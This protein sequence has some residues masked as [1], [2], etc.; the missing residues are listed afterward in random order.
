MSEPKDKVKYLL[1][2]D[3]PPLDTTIKT[4]NVGAAL[5]FGI[6]GFFIF[7]SLTL[8]LTWRNFPFVPIP[9][10][11][12]P[13]SKHLLGFW[14]IVIPLDFI[15][16]GV[17][18][19]EV[20]RIR[21]LD[22]WHLISIR[23]LIALAGG[24]VGGIALL[25]VGLTPSGGD[26]HIKGKLLLRGKEA[27]NDLWREFG[28]LSKDGRGSGLVVAAEKRFDPTTQ[29]I[30][31][32]KRGSFIEQPEKVRR[33]HAMYLGGTGRGKT[34]LI[35]YRL[36]AQLYEQ[37]RRGE[38]V[39]LLIADTPKS[40]YARYFHSKHVYSIAPAE[41]GG[42]A[43]DL[44]KDLDHDLLANA[45][46]K[47]KIPHNESDPIWGN[48]AIA[49]GTGCTKFLQRVAPKA[50]NYGMLAHMLTLSGEEL[51]PL[52]KKY[53][54]EAKQILNAAGETLT[55]VMFNLGTYSADF[56]ALG[57]IYDGFDIKTE[58]H[59]ATAKALKNEAYL[60]FVCND[61][62]TANLNHTKEIENMTRSLMFKAVCRHLTSENE[63]WTWKDFARFV[64][65]PA[66]LQASIAG[67][68]LI[69]ETEGKVIYNLAS[70]ALWMKL[71]STVIHYAEE[72]DRLESQRRLS[73]REWL[74]KDNPSR[75]ILLLKPSET[76][77]TL[78]EGLIKGILYY[79]NSVILGKLQDD[80]KRRLHILID[81]FQSYGNI[82]DF[83]SPALSMYRSRGVSI[84]IAFQDLAQLVKIYGQETVDFMNSNI[85]TI[86]ILGVNDGFTANKLTELLGEKKI[87]KLHRHKN[88][89]GGA[90]EDLQEHDEKVIYANE[91]N[92]LGANDATMKIKYLSLVAGLNPAYILE[93]PIIPY[94]VRHEVKPASWIDAE[95]PKPPKLVDLRKQW[96]GS[97]TSSPVAESVANAFEPNLEVEKTL[98][99][100]EEEFLNAALGDD[101][102]EPDWNK[103]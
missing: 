28:F 35:Y 73:I 11:S 8:L 18:G 13:F 23:Y 27:Y 103:M 25:K 100:F 94:K 6:A 4:V 96:E 72:W 12:L 99:E 45:F 50:W 33:S 51:E 58:V 82:K 71:A 26:K 77:P 37:I 102:E 47:G 24:F 80:R 59:Q 68:H 29:V 92:L 40:D 85:G 3:K 14:R 17:Y 21:Q 22:M 84:T 32:L 53:Y 42:M 19:E 98:D 93:A 62:I 52:L 66:Y 76:F 54:P 97:K 95:P 49:V 34:Q 90:N 79:A 57:R 7:A 56:I 64:S 63:N 88:S 89:D 60:E 78:T 70:P 86:N 81:E 20:Y 48:S 67:Q 38:I 65:L 39:K 30:S 15:K 91:W 55:S 2:G 87:Q 75:K 16:V 41:E 10:S 9:E 5:F 31:D 43:W 74:I 36:V 101:A 61:M 69:P 1:P 83:I 46:W 44:A